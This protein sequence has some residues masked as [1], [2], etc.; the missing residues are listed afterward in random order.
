MNFRL[1]LAGLQARSAIAASI[2]QLHRQLDHDADELEDL[3]EDQIDTLKTEI[4]D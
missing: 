1:E 2:D 4:S 3:I